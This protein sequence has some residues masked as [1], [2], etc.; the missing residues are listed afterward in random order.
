MLNNF[1]ATDGLLFWSTVVGL[2]LL[3]PRMV[4]TGELFWAGSDCSCVQP[5]NPHFF[6]ARENFII[7][8]FMST[9][10]PIIAR[11][12]SAIAVP[13]LQFWNSWFRFRIRGFVTFVLWKKILNNTLDFIQLDILF[14]WDVAA[15]ICLFGTHI[16]GLCNLCWTAVCS[17]PHCPL[18]CCNHSN[19]GYTIFLWSVVIYSLFFL[20]FGFG[21][22][23]GCQRV[24]PI[25][26]YWILLSWLTKFCF[27]VA[28]QVTTAQ[29]AVTLLSYI[30]FT[31]PLSE[32][33]YTSLILLVMG[34]VLKMMADQSDSKHSS[35]HKA[36]S[37]QLETLKGSMYSTENLGS[38]S[39]KIIDEEGEFKRQSNVVWRQSLQYT[40]LPG[41]WTAN[42]WT[43]KHF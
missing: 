13:G 27:S 35:H 12:Q 23:Q 38:G 32:Q 43:E 19:G 40:L 42:W 15:P 10:A 28:K 26:S 41:F 39:D 33:H 36:T 34:F 2:P 6:S 17:L 25:F 37:L 18:W 30:I 1:I 20:V 8:M 7:S 3:I 9:G 5:H 22:W 24:L 11:W 31:K 14:E 16:W 29:K 4:L 21:V